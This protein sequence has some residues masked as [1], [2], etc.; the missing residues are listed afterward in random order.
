MAILGGEGGREMLTEDYFIFV[1]FIRM[2]W[3]D[4]NVGKNKKQETSLSNSI[5][6]ESK[7]K[8]LNP[9]QNFLLIMTISQVPN[10][11]NSS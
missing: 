7:N 6:L 9:S 4:D 11:Q 10:L 2:L 8:S 5:V 1:I 3:W